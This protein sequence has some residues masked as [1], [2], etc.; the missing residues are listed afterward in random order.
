MMIGLVHKLDIF[1]VSHKGGT[2]S[3]ILLAK[4]GRGLSYAA[5]AYGG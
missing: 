5:N 4:W 3:T 1:F 2:T